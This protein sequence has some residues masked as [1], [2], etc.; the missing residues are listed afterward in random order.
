VTF[1]YESSE[2]CQEIIESSLIMVVPDVKKTMTHKG[3]MSLYIFTLLQILN[4]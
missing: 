3:Y 2:F 1:K 4:S